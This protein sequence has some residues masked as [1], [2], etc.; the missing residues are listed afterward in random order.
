MTFP[1]NFLLGSLH[2]VSDKKNVLQLISE[3]AKDFLVAC[4]DSTALRALNPN[5]HQNITRHWMGTSYH[6]QLQTPCLST[7]NPKFICEQVG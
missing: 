5:Y 6:L 1:V 3:S 7:S 4:L 2:F